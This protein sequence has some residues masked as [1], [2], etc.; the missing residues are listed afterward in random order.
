MEQNS[1]Y[2]NYDNNKLSTEE[3]NIIYD[4]LSSL[5]PSDKKF[6]KTKI[7]EKVKKDKKCVNGTLDFIL[8]DNIGSSYIS[9]EVSDNIIMESIEVL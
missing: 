4:L 2:E 1:N 6:D 8:L 5:L 7:L 3:F 9:N